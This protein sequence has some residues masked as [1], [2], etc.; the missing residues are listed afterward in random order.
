[1]RKFSKITKLSILIFFLFL[2]IATVFTRP[3]Y[4]SLKGSVVYY[5]DSLRNFVKDK[6]GLV[7]SYERFSPSILSSFFIKGI[8]VNDSSENSFGKIKSVKINYRILSLLKGDFSNFIK[9]VSIS[10]VTVHLDNIIDYALSFENQEKSSSVDFDYSIIT[11]YI[12]S[13]VEIKNVSLLYQ[14]DSIESEIF[15]KNVDVLNLPFRKNIEFNTE[16]SAS[17]SI[18]NSPIKCNGNILLTGSFF[19]GLENSSIFCKLSNFSCAGFFVDNLNFLA[20][21][22]DSKIELNSV[23]STIPLLLSAFY[24]VDNNSAGVP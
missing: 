8:S 10:G 2:V 22:K 14:N 19:P 15:I 18:K 11:D 6:T 20:T 9:N 1:M 16:G 3:L 7:I 13:E 4:K 21:Y 12:P 24:Q 23:Q 17:L 5:T